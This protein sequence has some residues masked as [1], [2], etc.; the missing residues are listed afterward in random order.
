MATPNVAARRGTPVKTAAAKPAAKPATKA[1]AKP[2][3]KP[4]AKAPAKAPA[5]AA[6]QAK[7][8]VFRLV[9]LRDALVEQLPLVSTGVI[10][11]V[12]SATFETIAAAFAEGKVVDIKDFG[13]LYIQDRPARTGRNPQTGESISIPPKRV[14]KFRFSKTLRDLA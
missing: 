12:V 11:K 3:A 8:E 1:A 4:A 6:T 14:A 2:A 9:A 13:K 7:P 5:K 10:N